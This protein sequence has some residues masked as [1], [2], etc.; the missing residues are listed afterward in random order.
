MASEDEINQESMIFIEEVS[1]SRRKEVL[2]VL[3]AEEK[4]QLAIIKELS[5]QKLHSTA[6]NCQAHDRQESCSSAGNCQADEQTL[7]TQLSR[8]GYLS[9]PQPSLLS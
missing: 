7:I 5:R 8:P 1:V 9:F 2:S 4:C 3:N 6:G